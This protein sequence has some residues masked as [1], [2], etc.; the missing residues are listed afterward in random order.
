MRLR[1]D[2]A[3]EFTA[4]RATVVACNAERRRDSDIGSIGLAQKGLWLAF[5]VEE[6]PYPVVLEL[7]SSSARNIYS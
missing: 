7:D 2:S 4:R 6:R 3:Y 5:L 1:A